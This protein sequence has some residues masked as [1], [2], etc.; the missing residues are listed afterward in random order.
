VFKK[1]GGATASKLLPTALVQHGFILRRWGL[2][3]RAENLVANGVRR[4]KSR[5]WLLPF[6]SRRSESQ[7]QAS[8]L[9]LSR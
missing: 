9:L 1:L 7:W 8:S 2:D 5:G 3:R 4:P 6:S